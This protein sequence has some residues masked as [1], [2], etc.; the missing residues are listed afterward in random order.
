MAR[1]S[2][3][4][5]QHVLFLLGV[6]LHG[7]DEIGDQ[8]GAALILVLNV[9]PARLG[10]LFERR[11]GVVAAGGERKPRART[12]APA[13]SRA[14]IDMTPPGRESAARAA[15][16]RPRRVS[17]RAHSATR[18]RDGVNAW[19]DHPRTRPR[20]SPPD[21]D[22]ALRQFQRRAV[23]SRAGP[24]RGPRRRR[25]GRRPRPADGDLRRDRRRR[26]RRH[27]RR[28]RRHLRPIRPPRAVARRHGGAFARVRLLLARR[29]SVAA[30]RSGTARCGSRSTAFR[31]RCWR[32]RPTACRSGCAAAPPRCSP[33][34]GRSAGSSASI[35]PRG[36]RRRR[37]SRPVRRARR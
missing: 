30:S 15:L 4:A 2:V 37:L 27:R 25:Q 3:T 17:N 28:L 23:D 10:G 34:P 7:L 12:S 14:K 24:D 32:S 16:H 13:R 1:A 26:P 31:R 5:D 18:R 11:N 22:R 9:R 20:P 8:V 6:A 36:F 33:S 19:G 21:R 29:R 35:S